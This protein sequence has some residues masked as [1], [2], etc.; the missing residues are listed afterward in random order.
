MSENLSI[1][2]SLADIFQLPEPI[3]KYYL[4]FATGA[5]HAFTETPEIWIKNWN[6]NVNADKSKRSKKAFTRKY[7]ISFVN[8]DSHEWLF[9]GIIRLL[10]D[11]GE[12]EPILTDLYGDLVGRLVVTFKKGRRS[13]FKLNHQRFKEIKVKQILD[14]PIL[15]KQFSSYED[16]HLTFNELKNIVDR[17]ITQ[18]KE[19][20]S[21]VQGIY[22]IFDKESRKIY[23]GKA[24]GSC[25]I[26]ERWSCY[27]HSDGTG[28]NDKLVELIKTN[29]AEYASNF[30]FTL[31][32]YAYL[33]QIKDKNYFNERE[34]Y[35]KKVFHSRI[36]SVG[37]NA[38]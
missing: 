29:G 19:K 34:S 38:N 9:G 15:S 12:E 14:Q 37:L 8:Y 31:L 21:F 3:D 35:W 28:Y 24:D 1:T 25:G 27:A 7:I 5:W 32:E 13:Y 22:L 4:H 2:T 10:N 33:G 17:Q 26:W 20:L 30:E 36:E 6:S 23:I 11:Q 18:W 16:V